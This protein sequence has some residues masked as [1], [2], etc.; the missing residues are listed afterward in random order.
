MAFFHVAGGSSPA[1]SRCGAFGELCHSIKLIVLVL[2]TCAML[3]APAAAEPMRAALSSAYRLNP[4]IDAQRARLRATDEDVQ[5]ARSGWAPRIDGEAF[6]GIRNEVS[7]PGD[8]SFVRP[9]ELSV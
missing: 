2:G 8:R 3:A 5:R 9:G 1:A 6:L 7:R 4:E